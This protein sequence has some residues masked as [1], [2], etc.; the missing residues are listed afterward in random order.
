MLFNERVPGLDDAVVRHALGLAVD[1]AAIIA[2]A[3]RGRGGL[4]Q[5]GA[6][7]AGLPWAS[8][9][10]PQAF[11]SPQAAAAA[12]QADG[13]AIGPAGVRVRRGTV[14]AFSL[15]VP[16]ADPLPAVAGEVARQL[17]AIG[18]TLSVVSVSP[19]GFVSGTIIPHAFDIALGDWDNVP[20]PDVSSFWRSN[21]QPPQGFNVSGG[22][23]DPFLDQALDTLATASDAQARVAAAQSVD[24]DLLADAPAVFLY[25]PVVSYVV[26]VPM[27]VFSI[28]AT[29]GSAARF[30]DVA[31][32]QRA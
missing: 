11:T 15:V 20:D 3:L 9:G 30:D 19:A 26:R 21:A 22:A 28:S 2:G 5:V 14:L 8:R 13:W 4:Q 10:S 25:T 31:L 17:A 6:V 23:T 12:L 16:A 1:R 24:R 18:V 29:G 7:S 27:R 32:W